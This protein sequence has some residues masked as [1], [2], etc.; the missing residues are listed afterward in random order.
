MLIHSIPPRQEY[1]SPKQKP[2]IAAI[3]ES[4]A[5]DQQDWSATSAGMSAAEQRRQLEARFGPR[6]KQL[7]LLLMRE[8]KAQIGSSVDRLAVV[9]VGMSPN[10]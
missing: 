3:V 4:L 2:E 8:T 7:R 1:V 10:D 5:R 9:W 6:L